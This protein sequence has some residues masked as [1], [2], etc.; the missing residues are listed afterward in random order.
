MARRM[1][2]LPAV[3]V[4]IGGQVYYAQALGF[5]K[6]AGLDVQIQGIDNGAAIALAIAGGAAD[7]GQSNVVSIATA[8]EKKLPFVVIAPAGAYSSASPTT[9]LLTLLD[10]PYKTAKDLNGKTMGTN[11]IL[12]IAQIG[13]DAWLDK[14][15]GDFHSVR[16]IE[17]PTSLTG[18]ALINH[19][20]DAAMS[21][22]PAL[23]AA[24]ATG[25]RASDGITADLARCFKSRLSQQHAPRH[26]Y[27]DARCRALSAGDR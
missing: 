18:E 27:G 17:I 24:L 22:E 5:F 1:F 19:R 6:Q 20:V 16:W 12:N 11:G 21:A 3:A 14:Y 10:A 26:V 9:V 7:I 25:K 2:L 15:G 8:H 23:G 13:G 4:D